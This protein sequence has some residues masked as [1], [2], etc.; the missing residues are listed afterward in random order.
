MRIVGALIADRRL[1]SWDGPQLSAYLACMTAERYTDAARGINR[2][3]PGSGKW[4]RQLDWFAD[5][6]R[7]YGPPSRVRLPFSVSTLERG[8]V[9]L[10]A[11]GLL[12]RERTTAHPFKPS[13]LAGPR[14]VYTN[15]FASK[16]PRETLETDDDD[17]LADIADAEQ[18][19]TD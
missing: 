5:P 10:E 6:N 17:L 19:P 11:Q 14:I 9:A 12:R 15:R 1:A 16:L 13:R 2:K 3:I 18:D 4:F 7:E 8:M